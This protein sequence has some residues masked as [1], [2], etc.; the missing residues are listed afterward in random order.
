MDAIIV[1]MLSNIHYTI[2]DITRVFGMLTRLVCNRILFNQ[3]LR[4]AEDEEINDVNI[5]LQEYRLT[6]HDPTL[7]YTEGL[8]LHTT[9]RVIIDRCKNTPDY[10]YLRWEYESSD[11]DTDPGDDEGIWLEVP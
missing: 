6:L 8:I 7:S 1:D 11:S 3:V 9:L 5:L 2:W 4:I 10:I